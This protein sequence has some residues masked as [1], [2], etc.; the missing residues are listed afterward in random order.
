[1]YFVASGEVEIGLK[2]KQV[3]LGAGHF[4]GEI[5]ALRRSRRSATA[6]AVTRTSLLVL[7]AQDLHALMEREPRIAERIREV[8]RGRLGRDIVTPKGDLV[9]EE[10]E[11]ADTRPSTGS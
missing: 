3:R 10:L 1:M 4:F 2:H 9:V 7:D 8:V 6:T 11:E 5:A